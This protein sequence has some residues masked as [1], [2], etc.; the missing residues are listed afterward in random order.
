LRNLVGT[1]LWVG[2]DRL[3]TEQFQDILAA[4][5]RE[6]A[7]PTAPACGLFLEKVHYKES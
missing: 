1:L 4:K 7:A 6:R 3:S 2:T 5:N